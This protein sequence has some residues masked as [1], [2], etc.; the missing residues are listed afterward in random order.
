VISTF[1]ITL[2]LSGIGLA[3]KFSKL[4]EAGPRP[5]VLGAILWAAVGATSVGLQSITGRL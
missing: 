4:R 3:L 5:L 2:A 1:L